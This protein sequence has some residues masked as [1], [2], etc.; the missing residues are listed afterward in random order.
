MQSLML[1]GPP[2]ANNAEHC[3]VVGAGKANTDDTVDLCYH[4]ILCNMDTVV[5]EHLQ[6]VA[7]NIELQISIGVSMTDV[8]LSFHCCQF[9]AAFYDLTL[10]VLN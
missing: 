10:I 3:G 5:L 1:D 7:H 8:E 4:R 6:G 9:S 2:T